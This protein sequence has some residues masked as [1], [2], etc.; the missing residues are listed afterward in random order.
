MKQDKLKATARLLEIMDTLREQCPWDRKQTFETLRN[1]TIEET[2]ELADA[3]L[4]K[5]LDGIKEEA[6]DLLLH[7]V[8]YAKLGEEAGAF[9]YAD[10]VN[11]LCDKLVYRHPHIYGEVHADTP[12]EVK[13]NWEAL[14]LRKKN[15]RSGTLGG[16]P[17]SLPALVKAYRIG[18]KAAATGFDWE[19]KED[20]WAKVKEET[21]EVEA[22][23]TSGDRTAMEEEFGD[24]LFAL[25]NACRL[26][27]ID[28]ESA[29]ERSNKKF[30]NRFNYME[31][32]AS[33]EGH[34]LHELSL[35]RMEELWQQAK[36]A[37]AEKE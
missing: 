12:E 10:V 14:K 3:I 5:D 23:M 35:D 27:G 1:N 32:C 36:H 9:D 16:V 6:G 18:E 4:N 29:L 13:A 21:A 22:E 7:V 19:K 25:V 8:F 11:A 15:R 20:V 17:V 31:E 33:S 28:P 24:L 26:Y 37:A 34:T 2:C 30:M